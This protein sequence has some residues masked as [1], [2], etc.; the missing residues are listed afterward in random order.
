MEGGNIVGIAADEAYEIGRT[1]ATEG[2][3]GLLG[4]QAPPFVVVPAIE[5]TADNIVEAYRV[6]LAADPPQEVLDAL[7][8]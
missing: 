1:M 7:G 2:A 8:G 5:V 6:S 4:K 3:Y